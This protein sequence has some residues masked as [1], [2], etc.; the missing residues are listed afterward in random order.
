MSRILIVEDDPAVSLGLVELLKSERHD[1]TACNSGEAALEA[2][3]QETYDL[4]LLDVTLPGINGYEVCRRLRDI[5]F[6]N[7]VLMLS[8]RS[9]DVDRIVG[10]EVGADDYIT[11]PFVPREL[12]ARISAHLR[13]AERLRNSQVFR[14]HRRH[15]LAVMFTDISGYSR[16]MNENEA[17]GIRLL[18]EHNGMMR[19]AIEQFGGSV[20]EIIGDAFLARFE[21]A[22][23]AVNSGVHA[24][25][26]L[27]E[28]NAQRT[29]DEHI[30]VRIGVHI[31]DV[32]D[33]GDNMKGDAVNVAAR[34][35]QQA[36]PGT[37]YVSDDV[38][39][40]VARKTDCSFEPLGLQRLKNISGAVQLWRTR[41]EA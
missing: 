38:Y 15:L 27:A 41:V 14:G 11:K 13:A 26:R 29:P 35:Q 18:T 39:K 7:P 1:V 2:A 20:V 34:I 22:V 9:M 37:L 17:R 30:H 24:L 40:I 4:A 6:A 28:R 10:L 25:R 3:Q 19:D 32:L 23:D 31:G 33:Y 36:E 16:T 12:T 5:G 8:A 21:S